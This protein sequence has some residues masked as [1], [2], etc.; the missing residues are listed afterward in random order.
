MESSRQGPPG[1]RGLAEAVPQVICKRWTRKLLDP[2]A[3]RPFTPCSDRCLALQSTMMDRDRKSERPPSRQPRL[4]PHPIS[5][6]QLVALL[7]TLR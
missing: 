1:G 2:A 7:I 4:C 3:L 5:S 6:C